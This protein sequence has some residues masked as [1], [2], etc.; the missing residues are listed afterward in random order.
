[1]I[2][3]GVQED[4]APTGDRNGGC[5]TALRGSIDLYQP[6]GTEATGGNPIPASRILRG[7]THCAHRASA[8]QQSG[9]IPAAVPGG[10]DAGA[11]HKP[12]AVSANS[13]PQPT[14]IWQSFLGV[15]DRLRS[16][17]W[18]RPA[19]LHRHTDTPHGAVFKLTPGFDCTS[20]SL[21]FAL[22]S[23]QTSPPGSSSTNLSVSVVGDLWRA[24]GQPERV[25]TGF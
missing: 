11:W 19:R 8:S 21:T 6:T 10:V 5:P 15:S 14:V 23:P 4:G 22:A 12:E 25:P 3:D 17:D 18:L 1:M 2:P 20:G 9:V 13:P 24:E 7:R 16:F